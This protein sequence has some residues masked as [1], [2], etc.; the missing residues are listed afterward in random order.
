MSHV[1]YSTETMATKKRM[2]N[3]YQLRRRT[4]PPQS[5]SCCKPGGFPTS[6]MNINESMMSESLIEHFKARMEAED[7]RVIIHV[8]C[9]SK[10]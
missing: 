3:G 10:F 2:L 7:R 4:I 5:C 9:F 6:L 1:L 8:Q